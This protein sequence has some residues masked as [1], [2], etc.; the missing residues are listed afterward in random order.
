MLTSPVVQASEIFYF[1]PFVG[2]MNSD[3]TRTTRGG[4]S[5]VN[6]SA[7]GL[8]GGFR[9]LG[10]KALFP[11]SP[12]IGTI[13]IE[14]ESVQSRSGFSHSDL[15]PGSYYDVDWDE[16]INAAYLAY[17]IP[18]GRFV[19]M[20]LR[21]GKADVR[22]RG[23]EVLDI[24]GTTTVTPIKADYTASTYGIAVGFNLGPG[25]LKINSSNF[26]HDYS[27]DLG[28]SEDGDTSLYGVSYAFN[29]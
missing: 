20:Q 10:D 19:F 4:D 21:G 12:G 18:F 2:L 14:L 8:V 22:V 24:G 15:D 29:F 17:Q 11:L 3:V 9:L 16:D 25:V 6:S 13:A 1:G 23:E 5:S 28:P 27:N 7:S 26:N